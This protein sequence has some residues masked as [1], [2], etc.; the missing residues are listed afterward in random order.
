MVL[1]EELS[2]LRTWPSGLAKVPSDEVKKYGAALE[3]F[4]PKADVVVGAQ[5]DANQEL[6][7]LPS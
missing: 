4:V 2:R 5:S 6:L 1:G 3:A 7:S